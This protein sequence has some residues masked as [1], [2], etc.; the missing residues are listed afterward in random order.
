LV[1]P[2]LSA[3]PLGASEIEGI[4][5]MPDQSTLATLAKEIRNNSEILSTDEAK[6]KQKVVLPILHQLGWDIFNE[7]EPELSTGKYRV[8]Y[9][10]KILNS[11]K[12]F[13]EVKRP[14]EDPT[15]H[16]EQLLGYSFSE[17]IP[18]AVLTNG[19]T[20]L[21]YLPLKEGGSWEQRKFYTIDIREQEPEEV[22]ERFF[23]FLS[24]KSVQSGNALKAAED[25]LD[26]KRKYITIQQTLP[27]A[28]EKLL[29]SGDEYLLNLVSEYVEKL[30]GHRP[31]YSVVEEFLSKYSKNRSTPLPVETERHRPQYERK[32][33]QRESKTQDESGLSFRKP[34]SFT[35]LG[36]RVPVSSW[37]DIPPSVCAL[38]LEKHPADFNKVL[39]IGGSKKD[40]FDTNPTNMFVPKKI[41]GSNIYVETNWSSSGTIRFCGKVLY[42]FG[43]ND[44]DL[45]VDVR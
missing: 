40:Y 6:I 13:L 16:Q 10:L 45:Q 27:K 21:F 9:A 32:P 44:N 19:I 20:W 18:L 24:K 29:V 12:V 37:A 15:D 26:D 35:F 43:Y 28:W 1:T 8:D 30:C 33:I 39:D 31:D 25:V 3:G 36:K 34:V 23:L 7:L 2:Q 14:S 4:I 22:A 17:G 11:Y 42:A 38:L 41:P 5:Y